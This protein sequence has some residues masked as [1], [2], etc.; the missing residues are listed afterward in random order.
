M[1]KEERSLLRNLH[2]SWIRKRGCCKL[3]TCDS[4]GSRSDPNFQVYMRKSHVNA[5]RLRGKG[6]FQG[7]V[8]R[9]CNTSA[10]FAVS[11]VQENILSFVFTSRFVW[12]YYSKRTAKSQSSIVC[13]FFNLLLSGQRYS[14]TS[15]VCMRGLH[16]GRPMVV[17]TV[18]LEA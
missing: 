12:F 3:K 2:Q 18:T 17:H 7:G 14:F 5:P 8:V 4:T 1:K 13:C 10:A 15:A 6:N 9:T 11:S 16:S